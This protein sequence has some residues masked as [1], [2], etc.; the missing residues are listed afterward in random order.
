MCE[1]SCPGGRHPMRAGCTSL[2][3]H[4]CSKT[5]VRSWTVAHAGSTITKATRKQQFMSRMSAL[6]LSAPPQTLLFFCDDVLCEIPHQRPK[7]STK[8]AHVARATV[9]RESRESRES[10]ATLEADQRR[11]HPAPDCV[12]R[13]TSPTQPSS[14]P[15]PRSR[16]PRA[17]TQP[18]RLAP[19]ANHCLRVPASPATM[20]LGG[21][22]IGYLR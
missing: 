12:P 19:T 13:N 18:A 9:T 11:A 5:N 17:D 4:G 10:R 8:I 14:Q 6:T 7:R 16:A 15:G 1:K 22:K 3:Q 20:L 2:P 21:K